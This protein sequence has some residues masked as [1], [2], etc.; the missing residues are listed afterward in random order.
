MSNQTQDVRSQLIE[1]RGFLARAITDEQKLYQRYSE[2]L[3]EADRWRRRSELAVGKGAND[4][5]RNALERM[6]RY[7]ARA[8]EHYEQYLEQKGYVERMKQRL[9]A[10]EIQAQSGSPVA[11]RGAD[12]WRIEGGL[13]RLAEQGERA[14]DERR[15]LAAWAEMERDELAEKLA[16]LERETQLEQQLDEL[17]RKLGRE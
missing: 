11:P 7:S 8:A 2:S 3:R 6:D 16:K 9:R 5:A 13:A 17:K 14:S 12:M 15:R 4:L 1:L 10:L